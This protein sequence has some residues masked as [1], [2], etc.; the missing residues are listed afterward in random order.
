LRNTYTPSSEAA[1]E[2]GIR[3]C[4]EM[5][6]ISYRA[7]TAWLKQERNRET[8]LEMLGHEPSP[9]SGLPSHLGYRQLAII[10]EKRGEFEEATAVVRQARAQGWSG[11][12]EKRI[13][14]CEARI[15]KR[16]ARR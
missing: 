10:L 15:A 7:A 2:K 9:S 11:D 6:A 13:A 12:W 8:A 1:V 5:I 3:I 14:R 16:D 4:R